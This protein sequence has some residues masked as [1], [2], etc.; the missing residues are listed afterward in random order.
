[1][2]SGVDGGTKGENRDNPSNRQSAQSEQKEKK[3]KEIKKRKGTTSLNT[4]IQAD[5]NILNPSN[6]DG[7]Q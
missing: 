1:M 6:S 4:S 3:G 2:Q 7:E 5:L